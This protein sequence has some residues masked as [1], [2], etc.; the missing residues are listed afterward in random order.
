MTLSVPFLIRNDAELDLVLPDVR[1][2]LEKIIEGKG[3][4]VIAWSKAGWV[5][6]F[7]KDRVIVPDDL[8]KQKL[9][10]NPESERLNTVFKT[11][12]F[13]LVETGLTDVGTRLASGVINAVYQTPAAVA[14]LGIYK[15][16]SNMLDLPIAPITGAIIMNRVTWNKISPNNQREILRVT[17]KIAEE[18]DATMPKTVANAVTMMEKEG[19]KV[20]KPTSS[21]EAMWRTAVQK[22]MPSLLGT[23]FDRDIYQRINDKLERTRNGQ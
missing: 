23:T 15:T 3:Y 4:V 6:V 21:Q 5:N 18:F 10:T 7:S 2:E 12:G 22:A 17:R 1:P 8:R 9:A 14:P 20:N 19:L 16:L 11:M 13:N